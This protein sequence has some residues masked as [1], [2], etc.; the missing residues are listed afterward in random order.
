MQD[1]AFHGR[2]MAERK[3]PLSRK[4]S[5]RREKTSGWG[6]RRTGRQGG[7]FQESR[8]NTVENSSFHIQTT[9]CKKRQEV[10]FLCSTKEYLK[11]TKVFAI[12]PAE[13]EHEILPKTLV[14]TSSI[15]QFLVKIYNLIK[16]Y[17]VMLLKLFYKTSR[18]QLVDLVL[19][20]SNTTD[21]DNQKKRFYR[22]TKMSFHFQVK[23]FKIT[24]WNHKRPTKLLCK[25]S[26]LLLVESV[27]D[28]NHSTVIFRKK[29][30]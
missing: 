7:Q 28:E 15:Y 1:L 14:K 2:K 16:N 12:R 8:K 27:L 10:L 4:I 24:T 13:R 22:T 26:G 25:T 6:N 18:S 21:K 29:K 30:H 3:P 19:D 9:I 11:G 5:K 23:F 17:I 20:V